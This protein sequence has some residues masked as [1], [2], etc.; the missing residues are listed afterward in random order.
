VS[1]FSGSSISGWSGAGTSGTSGYSGNAGS[2]YTWRGSWSSGSYVVNDCVNYN[3]NGYVCILAATTQNPTNA[4][5]WS[6]LVQSGTSGA[7]GSQGIS[8]YSGF[9]G[10]TA[11]KIVTFVLANG[12]NIATG[13]DQT[14]HIV[15]T[16]SYNIQKCY[17]LAKTGPVGADLICDININGTTIWAT[18]GNRIKVVDGQTYGTQT[19]FDTTS[20]AAADVLSIDVDQVGSSTPGTGVTVELVM[21]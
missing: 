10:T 17:A 4:S 21:A 5:Y 2:Q 11:T 6:L 3:G 19:S 16:G 1:G 8:G 9:S 15:I 7:T 14:N 20:L 18:Q 12:A 13:V